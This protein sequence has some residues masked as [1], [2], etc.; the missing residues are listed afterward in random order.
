MANKVDLLMDER[1]VS[2]ATSKEEKEIITLLKDVANWL[3]E[4]EIDQWGFLAEGGEDEEIRQAIH[5]K[6]TFVVK[7]N[8][9]IVAT[10]TLYK[11]QSLWDQHIWGIRN[12]RA[13]YLH[14]LAVDSS[15]IGSGLGIEVLKWAEN[16][17]KKD[18]ID[19]L[20]LDCVENNLKLNN[21]YSDNGF[22]KI[23]TND[24]HSL[25]QK[26]L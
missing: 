24:N 17:L 3:K 7:R 26:V 21:F 9:H 2:I 5:N 15:L 14:R 13:I 1:E 16:K 8:E 12:D 22:V 25:Y 19:T 10:L 23:S 20:R 6:E 18:G 4:K 11:K